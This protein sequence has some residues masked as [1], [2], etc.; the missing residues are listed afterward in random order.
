MTKAERTRQLIIEKAA[1]VFNIK[2]YESTSLADVQA[3]TGLTKGAIYGN[4]ADKNE[5]AIAAYE[6]SCSLASERMDAELKTAA[7]SQAALLAF[8]G[9][10]LKN[11]QALSERGGCPMLN[12]AVEA[13]DHLH[14]MRDSVRRSMD[15]VMKKLQHI[16]VQG[17][18]DGEFNP[19]ADAE[20]YAAI[21]F[22]IAE[23]NILLAK[24]MNGP[25]YLRNAAEQIARIVERELMN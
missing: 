14:F 22:S 2:G 5:L 10:Y 18:E 17:Q 9:Y 15:R 23:G 21:I 7:T 24:I 4:F 3:A 13:D 6:Y 12:A 16:I 25:K 1:P 8:I 11:W 19:G 20:K